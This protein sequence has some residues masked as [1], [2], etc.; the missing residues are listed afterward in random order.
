MPQAPT[1]AYKLADTN[2][3]GVTAV[4]WSREAAITPL[5]RPEAIASDLLGPLHQAD[6]RVA[7]LRRRLL[8]REWPED[9][10]I[11]PRLVPQLGVTHLLTPPKRISDTAFTSNNWSGST[12]SGTW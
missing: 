4:G 3:P 10:R 7:A 1:K 8:S 12:I 6:V 5:S 9:A 11:V 2:L